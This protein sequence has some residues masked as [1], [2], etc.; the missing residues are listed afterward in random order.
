[1]FAVK[2]GAI[3]HFTFGKM[4]VLMYIYSSMF[5]GI[6]FCLKR[7]QLFGLILFSFIGECYIWIQISVGVLTVEIWLP[8]KT[9]EQIEPIHVHCP[10][11]SCE[12]WG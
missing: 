8:K 5:Y 10:Y 2:F 3:Q 12:H 11:V 9:T 1:M 6:H 4:Y 7:F